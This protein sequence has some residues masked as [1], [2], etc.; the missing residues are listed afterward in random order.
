MN[1]I[2]SWTGSTFYV[3]LWVLRLGLSRWSVKDGRYTSAYVFWRDCHVLHFGVPGR[4]FRHRWYLTVL[5]R[6]IKS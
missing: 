1:I 5:G 3:R 2:L 4:P 6:K